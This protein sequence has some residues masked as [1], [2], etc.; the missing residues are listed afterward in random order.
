V[1]VAVN[2]NREPADPAT[3]AD[4]VIFAADGHL[5]LPFL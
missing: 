3:V 1:A 4:Q 5:P 2:D